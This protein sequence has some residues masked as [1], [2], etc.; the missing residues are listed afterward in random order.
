MYSSNRAFAE[1]VRDLDIPVSWDDAPTAL[2]FTKHEAFCEKAGFGL[3]GSHHNIQSYGKRADLCLF[4]NTDFFYLMPRAAA[5]T[6]LTMSS[7]NF[8]WDELQSTC[9]AHTTL[10]ECKLKTT[11]VKNNL[12]Y[13]PW[14]VTVRLRRTHE[15]CAKAVWRVIFNGMRLSLAHSVFRS[16]V[17]CAEIC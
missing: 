15:L 3:T 7:L 14:P 8:T 9:P 17:S 16:H 11:L 10:C 6:I 12:T 5:R 13:A 4:L 2:N 1:C